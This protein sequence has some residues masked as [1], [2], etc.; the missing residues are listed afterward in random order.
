V[1]V[2]LRGD[3][4]ANE[5]KVRKLLNVTDLELADSHTVMQATGAPL[6]FAGPIGLRQV[7]IVADYAVKA[8]SNFVVG[9]NEADMHYVDANYERDFSVERFADVRNAQAGDPAPG[10]NGTLKAAKGI[11]VGHVFML[12][13]KYSQS[14]KATFLDQQGHEQLAV[15]GCYGIGIGRTAASS[16]EQNHDAKGIIWPTPIAPFHVHLLPLSHSPAVTQAA[17]N[18]YDSLTQAGIEVLWDDRDERAGV[19]FNDADLIGAPYH[20]VIGEKGLA[21]GTVELK[22]RKTGEVQR[23]APDSV[24]A[25]VST[26]LLESC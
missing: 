23:L 9:G 26:L 7:R 8:L 17:Q 10:D 21:Q 13:T 19:K 25:T 24:V 20:V 15:M 6:G 12:G 2:L 1:A 18:L 22:A 11:E 14:M 3:H 4:T 5:I 16:I